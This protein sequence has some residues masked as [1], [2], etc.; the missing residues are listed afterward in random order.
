[1]R[2]RAFKLS[3]EPFKFAAKII[4]PAIDDS[5]PEE[6]TAPTRKGRLEADT[7]RVAGSD[8]GELPSG[9]MPDAGQ[10]K[11]KA[12]NASDDKTAA[13]DPDD[14]AS[15]IA[16]PSGRAHKLAGSRDPAFQ[17][18]DPD[19]AT[20]EIDVFKFENI[21]VDRQDAGKPNVKGG[22]KGDVSA[23]YSDE[24]ISELRYMI[25]EE[26]LAGDIYEA[27]Y[28]MYGLKVFKNIARSEDRHFN[29]V[30]KQADKIGIDTDE[31][32]FEPS[33][34]F[35]DAE[36][37]A[38]YDTLLETGSESLTAA[39]E[40]GVAIESKDIIDIA[41]AIEDVEGTRLARVY[42]NLL[43]GSENHLSAFDS[44]LV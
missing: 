5:L 41:A 39:L 24:A 36:L 21:T 27:F 17:R 16:A 3:D 26:K 19:E 22:G 15:E 31:F 14:D 8:D 32:L 7:A 29:A 9:A 23:T 38:L 10:A 1:M 42:D 25:E 30:I 12:R 44:L 37:Q 6:D 35:L 4:D 43:T 2:K 40:V 13:T 11:R 28:D 33:G 18:E 20:P 34:T